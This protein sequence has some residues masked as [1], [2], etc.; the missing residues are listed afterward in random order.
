MRSILILTLKDLRRRFRDPTALLLNL[1]IPLAIIG[2][3]FLAFG[4][5]GSGG[6]NAPV[7]KIVMVDL[8][9]TPLSNLL[10]GA[11]RNSEMAQRL[12]V[13]QAKTREEG[14]ALL[15][16]KDAAALLLI[17]QGFMDALLAGS[18]AE[19]ELIK[20]PSQSIMPI[21]AQQGLDVAA[22]YLSGARRLLGADAPLLRDLVKG[23]G[24]ENADAVMTLSRTI[25][26]RMSTVAD[27]LLPPIITFKTEQAAGTAGF[28]WLGWMYPGMVVMALLYIGLLQM[29]D[30]LH[31]RDGGTLR[32]L[33][34][35]PVGAPQ[36]LLSKVFSVAVVVAI[37]ELL[38][39]TLGAFVF[40]VKWVH[41]GALA[42][43]SLVIVFAVTGFMALFFALVRTERQGDAFGGIL[44][45]V[46]SLL[47]GAFI[48]PQVL[49][50][51]MQTVSKITVNHWANE[52]LRT[53]A[54]E[55]TLGQI[56]LP[57]AVLFALGLVSTFLGVL[58]LSRRHLRGAL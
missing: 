48:P 19:L 41:P 36:V 18:N 11:P 22:L 40:G 33:L 3:I 57:L 45:M 26:D 21:V 17:P 8:D 55:G 43:A 10:S 49:P 58:L 50:A 52:A 20:N 13:S 2:M 34:A 56:G 47:G 30:L 28:N 12:D 6:Q 37:A 39:L 35:A 15:K 51:A 46:M 42:V 38:L 25:Y 4:R 5:G 29:R 31:E 14:L 9:G 16:E 27:L 24:W 32:R 7:L 54:A 1:A 53:L 44:V 23:R